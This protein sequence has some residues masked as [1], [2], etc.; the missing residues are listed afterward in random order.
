MRAGY[1]GSLNQR[2]WVVGVGERLFGEA[3]SKEQLVDGHEWI[4]KHHPH[5]Q[6]VEGRCFKVFEFW[7]LVWQAN[8]QFL[9]FVES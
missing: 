1:I 5:P 3:L 7:L 2:P 4:E 8:L 9:R 6:S